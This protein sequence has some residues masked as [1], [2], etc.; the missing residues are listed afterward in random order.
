MI[1]AEAEKKEEAAKEQVKEAAQPDAMAA[2]EV[3]INAIA[4]AEDVKVAVEEAKV[5]GGENQMDRLERELA[6]LAKEP[7]Q[8]PPKEQKRVLSA[9]EHI[10]RI[11][12]LF[13]AIAGVSYV[14]Q[15]NSKCYSR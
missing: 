1:S 10:E 8:E 13:S 12:T 6:E 5:D 11:F 14:R 15:R 3:Q 9:G 4:K 7:A 2:K